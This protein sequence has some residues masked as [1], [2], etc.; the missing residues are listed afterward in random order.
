MKAEAVAQWW[1]RT[2]RLWAARP[3]ALPTLT[4]LRSLLVDFGVI[5]VMIVLFVSIVVQV[6]DRSPVADPISVPKSLADAGYSGEVVTT[7]L[8]DRSRAFEQ[9]N[10]AALDKTSAGAATTGDANLS[11]TVTVPGAGVSLAAVVAGVRRFIGLPSRHIGGYIVID[12]DG[13]Y[14]MTVRVSGR[15]PVDYTGKANASID[16]VIEHG[17][18]ALTGLLRPCVLAAELRFHED[19]RAWLDDCFNDPSQR[20]IEWAYNLRGLRYF[21]EGRYG[22]AIKA[23]DEALRLSP[24]Y[25][26]ATDNRAAALRAKPAISLPQPTAGPSPR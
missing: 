4:P 22:D 7:R 14:R 18:R 3:R 9:R 23:Y 10:N 16:D 12:G 11:S 6:A 25:R 21:A 8:I 19:G 26:N 1:S 24:G 20:D 17:A 13:A 2:K 15:D 5:V